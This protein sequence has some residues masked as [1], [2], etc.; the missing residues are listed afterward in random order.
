MIFVRSF[1]SL[2]IKSN[3]GLLPT[4][5][6]SVNVWCKRSI[7][8]VLQTNLTF[9]NLDLYQKK[10]VFPLSLMV[11]W[12]NKM[13]VYVTILWDYRLQ[14][15]K[16]EKASFVCTTLMHYNWLGTFSFRLNK[17]FIFILTFG[18]NG[19]KSHQK[20]VYAHIGT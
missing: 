1:G 5:T 4:P 18:K 8:N 9:F 20:I 19:P 2:L 17:D 15:E 7:F 14:K 6:T 3:W 13:Y 10:Y 12:S 16:A 11:L